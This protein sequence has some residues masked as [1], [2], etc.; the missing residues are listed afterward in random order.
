M[1][2][3]KVSWND[4]S[5][6][7][8]TYTFPTSSVLSKWKENQEQQTYKGKRKKSN[9]TKQEIFQTYKE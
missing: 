5:L 7:I 1:K 8:S 9:A 6:L 3:T 2:W 4:N